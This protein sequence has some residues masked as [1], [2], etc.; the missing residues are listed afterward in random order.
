ML[1]KLRAE[2]FRR[3]RECSHTGITVLFN[4]L[5][6]E[7]VHNAPNLWQGDLGGEGSL[8]TTLW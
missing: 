5:E 4:C 7:W 8:V 1:P 6:E 2:R 3:G